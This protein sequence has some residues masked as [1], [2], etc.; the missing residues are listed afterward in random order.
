[1]ID[2]LIKNIKL[3]Q[4]C[5]KRKHKHAVSQSQIDLQTTQVIAKKVLDL[6]PKE[7]L[8]E[9]TEFIEILQSQ[10]WFNDGREVLNSLDWLID[11]D[12]VIVTTKGNIT[13]LARNFS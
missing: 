2:R 12:K 7:D 3:G 6:M 9:D 8:I 1:M 5:Y 4:E 13:Y 10:Q 11:N